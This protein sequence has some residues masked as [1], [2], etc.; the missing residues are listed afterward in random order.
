[1]ALQKLV[2]VAF[3][4]AVKLLMSFAS[5]MYCV[6][7]FFFLLDSGVVLAA[8]NAGFVAAGLP[9]GVGL[10]G[11]GA[12]SPAIIAGVCVLGCDGSVR[13]LE[14]ALPLPD[15]PKI[16]GIWPPLQSASAKEAN[17]APLHRPRR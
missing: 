1:M 3:A 16:W 17:V 6:I 9:R 7:V 2:N 4:A 12:V 15:D 11:E 8:G 14:P 5:L 10:C 13:T